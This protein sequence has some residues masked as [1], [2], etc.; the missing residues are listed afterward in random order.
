MGA[1][2][3]FATMLTFVYI[4]YYAVM[5]GMDLMGSKGKKKNDVE[6]FAIESSDGDSYVEQPIYVREEDPPQTDTFEQE[7]QEPSQEGEESGEPMA[8][9]IMGANEQELYAKAK[10]AEKEMTEVVAESEDEVASDDMEKRLALLD[11][12]INNNMEGMGV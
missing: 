11:S 1:F 3:I 12:N 5:I 6:V 2:G 4:V 7:G 8:S 9:K 10:E